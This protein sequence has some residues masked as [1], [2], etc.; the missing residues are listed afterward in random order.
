M[1]G[2]YYSFVKVDNDVWEGHGLGAS[3]GRAESGERGNQ[4]RSGKMGGG[5]MEGFIYLTGAVYIA[6][7][8]AQL[9]FWMVDIIEGRR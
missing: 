1:R 8:V 9:T 3:P 6:V 7:T 2:N 4:C 5:I